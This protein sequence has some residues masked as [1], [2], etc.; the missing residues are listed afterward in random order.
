MYITLWI[1]VL[2]EVLICERE[3]D[4]AENRYAV[5]ILKNV[6]ACKYVKNAMKL[7]ILTMMGITLKVSQK[8]FTSDVKHE[9][10]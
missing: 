1:L 2:E 4:N 3:L 10:C 5:A 7:I 8:T 9:I 6:D